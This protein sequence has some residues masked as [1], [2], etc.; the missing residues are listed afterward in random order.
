MLSASGSYG[1][2]A[3]GAIEP[4]LEQDDPRGPPSPW[5]PWRLLLTPATPAEAYIGP[6]AGVALV[7]SFLV[8]L[9]TIVVAVL[10]VL[11][12]PFRTLWR[13]IRR[14]PRGRPAVRRLIIVGFDGQDPRLTERWMGEGKLPN[15]QRLAES[16]CFHRLRTS[17][18][19][20]SPVA[21]SCFST[22]TN[23]GR[24]NIFDFLDRDPRTYLPRLSSTHIG[25]VHRFLKLGRL[26]VPL[27]R[28]ELR[29]LRRSKPFWTVLGEHNIWSTVLRVPITFPPDR[30]YGAELSA[31][32]VPDLLGTQGTFH[33][34]TTRSSGDRFKEGGHPGHAR[35]DR[36]PLHRHASRDRRTPS[37]PTT[38]PLP[39]RC[40][41]RWT[42]HEVW[43]GS[44][45]AAQRLEL[46]PGQLS[47]WVTL[48]F[49]AAP[50]IKVSGL[51]RV[52][53][54]EMG[55]HVSLYV[56][57]IN[58]DPDK[59]A[60][61]ISHPDYYA[62]Y[63]AKKIGPFATLGLAE[64]TWALNEKV[65]DDATFLKLDLRHRRRAGEDA[66]RRPR[67]ARAT[68]P[69]WSCSTPPTASSTCSGATWRTA[70]RPR[71]GQDA[72]RRTATPSS[73]STVTTT[74]W[75]ASSSTVCATATC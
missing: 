46:A 23:P 55:E 11:A 70:T 73:S 27:E 35:R 59:P 58:L 37:S 20:V 74:A 34:F 21:W 56:S 24:H 50:G 42:G 68:A 6:G 25:S 22:G 33:L 63:L 19:S 54:T 2:G 57:P 36:R 3:T 39:C 12:W 45:S 53:L 64:D 47:D 8:L 29:L 61:P 71:E 30:F 43:R 4:H 16:G 32:C 31:M 5:W 66:R 1:Q 26:R 75:W 38:P 67:P 72:G 41:S 9:T 14:R 44:P 60:M 18:P 62:T 69:S 51:C 17:T 28:P 7:G 48:A 65:I 40:P 13:V 49:P 10:S 15:F 52:Q